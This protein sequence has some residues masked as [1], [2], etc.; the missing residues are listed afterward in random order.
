[1]KLSRRELI[2]LAAASRALALQTGD[3]G[4]AILKALREEIERAKGLELP[5]VEKPYFIEF[6]LDDTTSFNAVCSLGALIG[7]STSRVRIPRVQVRVGSPEFD[8]T[9]YVFSQFFGARGGGRLPL[10]DN[11]PAIRRE[12][13]LAADAAYKAALQVIA[14]KRAALRNITQ[15]ENIKDFA[16]APAVRHIEPVRAPGVDET[17]WTARTRRISAV[18]ARFPEVLNSQAEFGANSST[19]YLVNSEGAEVRMP[20]DLYSMRIRASAQAAD[21]MPIRDGVVFSGRELAHLP[22]EE[23]MIK[24]AEETGANIR[25]LLNA[26]P[27]E[28]YSGPVL[29]EGVA[30]PQLIAQLLGAPLGLARKP[31]GEPGRPVPVQGSE[32]EGRIGS[33]ILP[34]WIDAVDDPTQETYRGRPLLGSY[35]VDMEGVKPVPLPVIEKGALKNFLLSRQPVRGFE[36]SN[37]RGR[38][39]SPFGGKHPAFSNLFVKAHETAPAAGMKAKLLDLVS[40]RS[41]PYGLIIRKL[42]LP[43]ML[44]NEELRALGQAAS[45]RGAARVVSVPILAYKVYPDGREELVRGMRFRGVSSRSLRDLYAASDE[46]IFFDFIGQG[47]NLASFSPSG[48]VTPHTVVCPALLF[49]DME[50]E[51]RNDDWPKLPLVPPPD[52]S[53]RA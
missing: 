49:E 11:I 35:P 25:A 7:S 40:K 18:F 33:R 38:L 21:G 46:E 8:N 22:G 52:L 31:V 45:Q 2:A 14:R 42:D 23:V 41:L 15:Q 27:G 36:G 3:A 17:A 53:G 32:L 19:A 13:W 6:A 50:L 16:A 34:E 44:S 37:G 1:M 9:N 26:P 10:E 28:D 48:Y 12:F 47:G 51:K 5:G 39:P 29:F 43:V 20:D 24:A 4:D 30:A